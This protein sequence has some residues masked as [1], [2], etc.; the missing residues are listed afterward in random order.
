MSVS[1]GRVRA[2]VCAR[3]RVAVSGRVEAI[4][5]GQHTNSIE[6]WQS[7]WPLLAV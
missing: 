5:M 7:S 3:D 4:L 1:A 6:N 2:R